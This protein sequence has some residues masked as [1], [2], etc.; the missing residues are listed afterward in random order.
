MEKVER[1]AGRVLTAIGLLLLL[2]PTGGRVNGMAIANL[3][4]MN[5]GLGLV[6]VGVGFQIMAKLT[7]LSD[8]MRGSHYLMTEIVKNTEGEPKALKKR[9]DR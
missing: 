6:I 8:D 7:A 9:F 2:F 5:L 3:S 4:L 1:I